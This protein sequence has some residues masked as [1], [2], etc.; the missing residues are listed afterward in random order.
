M[1]ERPE[2]SISSMA[3]YI[4]KV[5][6]D[7]GGYGPEL[8][9]LHDPECKGANHNESHYALWTSYGLCGTTFEVRKLYRSNT[10]ITMLAF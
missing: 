4:P 10:N 9:H 7:L 6:V 1:I 8:M 5:L 3:L 2:C